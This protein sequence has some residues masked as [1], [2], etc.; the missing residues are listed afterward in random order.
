MSATK[1]SRRSER[2]NQLPPRKF[3]ESPPEAE[4]TGP[5]TSGKT[6][7]RPTAPDTSEIS[8]LKS[9]ILSASIEP[10]PDDGIGPI[11]IF[12]PRGAVP[13]EGHVRRFTN[14]DVRL[15][16]PEHKA[17]FQQLFYALNQRDTRLNCG[18]HVDTPADVLRYLLECYS[19]ATGGS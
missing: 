14:L 8:N 1:Q 11:A 7:V 13:T 19:T 6:Q 5:I 9:Q 15:S 10:A 12:L 16:D 3:I 17:A 4:V 2:A 18:K